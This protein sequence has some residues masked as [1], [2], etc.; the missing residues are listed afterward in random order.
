MFKSDTLNKYSFK[1]TMG[2]LLEIQRLKGVNILGNDLYEEKEEIDKRKDKLDREMTNFKNI[3]LERIQE[4]YH[5]EKQEIIAKSEYDKLEDIVKEEYA[6]RDNVSVLNEEE[7]DLY[8]DLMTRQLTLNK[9]YDFFN[10]QMM[11]KTMCYFS[12]KPEIEFDEDIT[13]EDTREFFDYYLERN[14]TIFNPKKKDQ[15]EDTGK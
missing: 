1:I 7:Q 12:D 2:K 6:F 8:Y 5:I 11:F 4:V 13:Q 14:R 15:S 3:Y 9:D 10:K